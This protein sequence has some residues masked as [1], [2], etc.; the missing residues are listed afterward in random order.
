MKILMLH[1]VR[2]F[3]QSFFPDRYSQHSFLSDTAF[4]RGL[5]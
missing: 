5:D 2:P 1:D 3:D 4:I